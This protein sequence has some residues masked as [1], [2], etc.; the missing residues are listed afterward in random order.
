MVP[1][2]ITVQRKKQDFNLLLLKIRWRGGSRNWR[3]EKKQESASGTG[4]STPDDHLPRNKKVDLCYVL[5]FINSWLALVTPQAQVA[6]VTVTWCR[7]STCCKARNGWA[8]PGESLDVATVLM[9]TVSSSSHHTIVS[10]DHRV[11]HKA[12]WPLQD[13][14]FFM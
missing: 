7:P 10:G 14:H 12:R 5:L 2:S 3:Q 1:C 11:R 13:S 8:V 9:A 6:H 4:D